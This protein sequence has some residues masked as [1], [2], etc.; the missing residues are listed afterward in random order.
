M[1]KLLI[2]TAAALITSQANAALFNISY[3]FEREASAGG[4]AY[5]LWSRELVT[6]MPDPTHIYNSPPSYTVHAGGATPIL[7]SGTLNTTTGQIVLNGINIEMVVP[8]AN[9]GYLGYTQTLQGSFSGNTYNQTSNAASWSTF[10]C[11]EGMELVNACIQ[12]PF[13]T[14]RVDP[15]GVVFSSLTTGGTG[16]LFHQDAAFPNTQTTMVFTIGN[17]VA[18]PVPAAAWLFGSALLGLAGIGRK[19]S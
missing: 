14:G 17:E 1:K 12:A 15:D 6:A 4:P 2:A 5:Y 10:L 8:S 18:V 7:G 19:R 3:T 9:F 16:T 13:D 11:E